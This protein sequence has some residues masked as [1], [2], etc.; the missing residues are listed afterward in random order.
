MLFQT[1]N[2][3]PSWI[4]CEPKA[5]HLKGMADQSQMS[6]C[7]FEHGQVLLRT[8]LKQDEAIL[9]HRRHLIVMSYWYRLMTSLEII[10]W[11]MQLK[12]PSQVH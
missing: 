3:L 8:V 5:M 4:D 9:L 10:T 2:S 7:M 11:M 1:K 12:M 6:S